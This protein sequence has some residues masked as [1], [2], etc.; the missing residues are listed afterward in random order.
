[1]MGGFILATDG[2]PMHASKNN[3]IDPLEVLDKYGADAIR[4][5]AASCALGK[6]NAFRWKDVTEGVRFT[7][8]LWNVERLMCKNISSQSAS[9][10]DIKGSMKELND[11]DKWILSRY[12]KVVRYRQ[13]DPK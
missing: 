9:D 12:S 8:K 4:Y 11:I 1:M 3:V 7:R 13:M 10:L 5:Y 2:T 6:D